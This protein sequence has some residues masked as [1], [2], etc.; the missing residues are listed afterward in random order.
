MDLVSL[1]V[2]IALL[3]LLVWAVTELVP[4]PAQFKKVIIVVAIVV[5]VLYVFGA[6]N[7]LPANV[8]PVRTR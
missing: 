4:M 2:T 5:L 3:G 7:L 1:I 8:L 6:L